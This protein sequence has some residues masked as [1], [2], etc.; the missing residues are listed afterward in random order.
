MSFAALMQEAGHK[1]EK[2]RLNNKRYR[3]YLTH[4]KAKRILITLDEAEHLQ[5]LKQKTNTAR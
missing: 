2:I 5:R 1:R 4:L 3:D